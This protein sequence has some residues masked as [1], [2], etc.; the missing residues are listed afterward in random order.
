MSVFL[1]TD[2]LFLRDPRGGVEDV[3]AMAAAGFGAIFCNIGD[4][5]PESWSTIR[6]R[7]AAAGVACGPWLRTADASNRFDFD[8]FHS[9]IRCADDWASP[10]IVN[11]ESEIH[12]TGT[13][14]TTYIDAQLGDRDAAVSMEPWPFDNVGWWPLAKRPMMP[15]LALAVCDYEEAALREIWHAYGIECVVLTFGSFGGIPASAY[16]LAAPFGVYTADDC[17]GD[18]A[19]WRAR[20][21]VEPCIADPTPTPTPPDGDDVK[22]GSQDGVTASANR[23]RDLDPGGTLLVKTGSKWPSIDTLAGV[24]MDKWK[25]YDKLERALSILVEDHDK[26]EV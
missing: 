15:Q 4:H 17:G 23:W 9:L 3:A 16:D 2:H 19:S 7:A 26:A 24:P 18:Y 22:I 25:A 21:T 12:G 1:T 8:R 13:E 14:I 20:G 10:L 5:P 6:S 11:T